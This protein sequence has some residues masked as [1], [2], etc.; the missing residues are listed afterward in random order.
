MP[1]TPKETQE[2]I[3][4]L[5]FETQVC[6]RNWDL[7]GQDNYQINDECNLIT[8]Q[9]IEQDL[10]IDRKTAKP[11]LLDLRNNSLLVISMAV[12]YDGIPNGSGYLL[13]EKGLQHCLSLG[14]K[15]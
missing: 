3:L 2:N 11:I 15:E 4:K 12:D 9:F 13:T 5:F 6:N 8:Y 7:D 1:N 10:K 14:F